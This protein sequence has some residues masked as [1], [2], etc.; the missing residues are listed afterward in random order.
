MYRYGSV[1]ALL[2][3]GRH[4]VRHTGGLYRSNHASNHAPLRCISMSAVVGSGSENDLGVCR[5]CGSEFQTTKPH[6]KGY[7][8]RAAVVNYEKKLAAYNQAL[9]FSLSINQAGLVTPLE[10]DGVALDGAIPSKSLATT[11]GTDLDR[12]NQ[13]PSI[14]QIEQSVSQSDELVLSPSALQSLVHTEGEVTSKP[15]HSTDIINDD[16]T[17]AALYPDEFEQAAQDLLQVEE[18]AAFLPQP[19]MAHS[20]KGLKSENRL[21]CIPEPPVCQRCFKL[22][23]YGHVSPLEVDPEEAVELLRKVIHDGSGKTRLP[24]CVVDVFD[25][26]NSAMVSTLKAA[27]I[28]EV[29]LAIN[30]SDIFPLVFHQN[31][32]V[33]KLRNMVRDYMQSQGIK[34]RGVYVVSSRT[35]KGVQKLFNAVFDACQSA[36]RQAF[37]F[38][39]ANVGKSTLINCLLGSRGA[40][41]TSA[42]P[43]TT[44]GLLPFSLD[45]Q[46]NSICAYP[47]ASHAD[48]TSF[49]SGLFNEVT[50]IDTPGIIL[51]SHVSS[52]LTAEEYALVNPRKTLSPQTFLM[53]AGKAVL[54]GGL[55]W[56]AVDQCDKF[57][58]T[59]VY[60]SLSIHRHVTSYP[61]VTELVAS[62]AGTEPW[63]PPCSPQRGNAM[64]EMVEHV[65]VVHG[66]G[67]NR[68]ACDIVVSGVCVLTVA[69]TSEDTA[70]IRVGAPKGLGVTMRD[71]FEHRADILRGKRMGKSAAHEVKKIRQR[72]KP[73]KS[74]NRKP[75]AFQGKNKRRRGYKQ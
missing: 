36:D 43:G 72:G 27:N 73:K 21:P 55:A 6:T 33:G 41:T 40:A 17:A 42:L 47:C 3:Y 57:V 13:D 29:V 65:F 22:R 44:L 61:R 26:P 31:A 12:E 2:G 68:S 39:A 15:V 37:L 8:D 51:P 5:G 66:Q 20:V 56:V 67:L 14:E 63:T 35:G 58:Y 74:S 19:T 46:H 71:S 28:S 9:G 49:S 18:G 30:K 52:I 16:G 4:L 53:S 7:I 11:D 34:V 10:L 59:S 45:R 38:G 32:M 24:I 69:L 54:L 1:R 70:A 60:A 25:F 64:P 48:E 23:H 75:S 62:K 50:L